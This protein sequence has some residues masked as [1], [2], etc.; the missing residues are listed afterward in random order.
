MNLQQKSYYNLGNTFYRKGETLL[1]EQKTNEV[2]EIW[3]DSITYYQSAIEIDSDN[4][5]KKNKEFVEE[6]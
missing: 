3:E 6:N 4:L 5:A 2:I 1:Q